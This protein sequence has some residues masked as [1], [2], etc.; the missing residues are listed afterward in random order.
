MRV[1]H[2]ALNAAN[3]A[4][5]T[6]WLC[7]NL[8]MRV[9]RQFGDPPNAFF[10]AD[11]EGHTVLEIYNNPDGP[12]PDYASMHP[13][14]LHLAFVTDDVAGTLE[15]LLAAGR[16]PKQASARRREAMSWPWYVLRAASR[17]SS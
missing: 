11:S 14:T 7:E 13:A 1:E 2:L 5:L 10:V 3:P 16:R 8:G 17:S 9:L 15:R 12:I 4:E 6:G